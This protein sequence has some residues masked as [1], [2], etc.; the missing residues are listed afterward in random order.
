MEK[1]VFFSFVICVFFLVFKFLEMKYIEQEYNLTV[2]WVQ[3]L[4]NG[5]VNGTKSGFVLYNN[6][7]EK[8]EG[9]LPIRLM[10]HA[11]QVKNL[12]TKNILEARC[13]G[14]RVIF[15]YSVSYNYGI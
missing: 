15:P 2:D 14:T 12:A 4:K 11:P 1:L 9:V 3:Q 8:I 5:F 6:S 10:P 7:E 13:G